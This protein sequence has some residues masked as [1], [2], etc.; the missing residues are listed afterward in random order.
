MQ[1]SKHLSSLLAAQTR[2]FSSVE[3]L[4]C[5]PRILIFIHPGSRI[6]DPTTAL[7]EKGKKIAILPFM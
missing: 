6:P 2:L 4:G 7:K 3:D 1:R 5:L